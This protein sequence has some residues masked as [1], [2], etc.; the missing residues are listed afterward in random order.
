VSCDESVYNDLF[1]ETY[2]VTFDSQGGSAVDSQEVAVGGLA[3]QPADPVYAGRTFAGW[4]RESACINPWMFAS[5]VVQADVTLYARWTI[6]QFTLAYAAGANGSLT[7]TTMQT[8]NYGANGTAVT[9]VPAA[10][11]SFIQWSDGSTVNPRTDTNVIG[12]IN[13]TAAFSLNTFT[14]TYTAGANGSITGISPQTVSYGAN[15][16]TV[17]A[18]P[19][20]NYHFVQW[21]DGSTVNPRTDTGVTANV[22]VTASFSI[23]T[24]S[25]TYTAGANGSIT[26]TSPQT[27]NYGANGTAVTAV[28]NAG[29]HF[30]Q[31]DDGV[32]TNTRTDTN[33]TANVS[34]TASFDPN[35]HQVIYNGNGFTSGSA[36][37]GNPFTCNYNDTITVLDNEWR[38]PAIIAGITQRFTGWNTQAG[39]GGTS[40]APGAT[41]AMPDTDVTLYAQWTTDAAVEGKIGPAGGFIFYDQGSVIN[42]WQYLEAAPADLGPMEWGND[43]EIINDQQTYAYGAGREYTDAE[44]ASTNTAIAAHACI[45]YNLNGYADWFLPSEADLSLMNNNLYTFGIGN[46]QGYS[47]YWSSSE[48]VWWQ[49]PPPDYCANYQVFALGY[50]E[51]QFEYG[52]SYLVRPARRF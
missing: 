1:S 42:G 38:G 41:F 52:I 19:A 47:G 3:I 17:T 30:V 36:P 29:Y 13:V 16:T 25:L 35:P 9:A 45:N 11:Y 50:N 15:G 46:F 34:V 4:F 43:I 40:Y 12:N 22:S 21:S 32:F 14:L 20:A 39:G 48:Q 10:G 5:D 44:V 51:W 2:V 37:A 18:V 23:D 6:N 31:W 27:V 28:P 33:V 26:G 24:F 7:G 49:T 8:V